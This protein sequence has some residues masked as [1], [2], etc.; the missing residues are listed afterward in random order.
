MPEAEETAVAPE[1][2]PPF[3]ED[4]ISE[5]DDKSASDSMADLP[6]EEEEK[7][8][9]TPKDGDGI[10]GT[11]QVAKE[12]FSKYKTKVAYRLA[13]ALEEMP[14]DS[15]Y[16][17]PDLVPLATDFQTMRKKLR[18][19]I[20]SAK[21]YQAATLKVQDARSKVNLLLVNRLDHFFRI[22]N[23]EIHS[24][25]KNTLFCRKILLFTTMSVRSWT[26]MR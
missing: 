7:K 22:A 3:E 9:G 25:T 15:A 20:A 2:E 26:K 8:E 12:D 10:A 18:S 11:S 1:M 6:Q 5:G 19:L 17:S 21:A 24:Y 14:T 23:S 4:A 16:R 13:K